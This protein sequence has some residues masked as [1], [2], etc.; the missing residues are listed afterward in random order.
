MKEIIREDECND[1]YGR[2]LMYQAMLLKQPEGIHI[3]SER[4]VYQVMDQIGLSHR[5]K[6][7]LNGLINADRKV[8]KSD[9]LL[10]RDFQSDALL[11]KCITEILASNGKL[12]VSAIFDYFALSALGLAIETNMK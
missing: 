4:I 9:G 2:I 3:P 10:K 6:R 11:E 12:Y 5:A 7:K 1:T 8:M